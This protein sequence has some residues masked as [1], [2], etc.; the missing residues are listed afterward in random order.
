M[1]KQVKL[2][3]AE[4]PHW[5]DKAQTKHCRCG[6]AAEHPG[7]S[8]LRDGRRVHVCRHAMHIWTDPK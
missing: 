5:C 8:R 7:E 3:D 2:C 4:S 6:V 1:T